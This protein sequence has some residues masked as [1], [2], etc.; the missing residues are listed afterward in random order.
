MKKALL[1][2]LGLLIPLL[3]LSQ[4]DGF[5]VIKEEEA[6][7]NSQ[8]E[9]FTMSMELIQSLDAKVGVKREITL[10]MWIKN[11]SG[12]QKSMIKVTNPADLRNMGVLTIQKSALQ[13]DQW[14]YLPDL[15]RSRRIASSN[16]SDRFMA[17]D[18]TFG[19]LEP[20][21]L[22]R[23]NFRLLSEQNLGDN[24]C[25]VV[26]AIPKS[27]Q[28]IKDYGYSK[29]LIWVQKS[30]YFIRQIEYYD[31]EGQKE[32]IQINDEIVQVNGFWRTNK[33]TVRN[34]LANH[35][36][37]LIFSKRQINPKIEDDFFSTRYLEK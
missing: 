30:N 21:V 25:Y 18:I 4:I 9:S 35:M 37:I 36:T 5:A 11:Q 23:W 15:G 34:L 12:L 28:D 20:E 33:I 1:F 31:K 16:K 14:L 26:E 24:T 6:R 7:Y 27:S 10:N 32:K 8:T 3:A 17:S 19:D 13:S 2:F 29:R 22:E